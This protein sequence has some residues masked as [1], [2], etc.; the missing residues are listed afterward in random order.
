MGACLRHGQVTLRGTRVNPA[1]P[2]L[3]AVLVNRRGE[4]FVDEQAHGYS[5]LAGVVQAQ[6]DERAVMVWDDEARPDRPALRDDARV[7]A[8]RGA[9]HGLR[10]RQPRRRPP[11]STPAA[12]AAA[13]AAAARPA[14]PRRP[15]PLR[16]ADPRRADDPGRRRHRRQRA[17]A[18]H[19]RHHGSRAA[20]RRRRRRRAWP[21]R[22][23]AGYSSGNG[24]LSAFGMGWIVGNEVAAGVT[25]WGWYDPPLTAAVPGPTATAAASHHEVAG[26]RVEVG[27]VRR[28]DPSERSVGHCGGRLLRWSPPI[29]ARRRVNA[30]RQLARPEAP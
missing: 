30:L 11:A 28:L 6:P 26:Q 21:A 18:A 24:L 9:A 1:L 4:R 13:L 7:R 10:R 25:A 12:L 29:R 19:R 15:L 5:G 14:G 22:T 2:W 27:V 16:L 20:C 8:G 17:G 3:G 23:P